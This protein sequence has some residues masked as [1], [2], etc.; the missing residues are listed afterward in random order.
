MPSMSLLKEEKAQVA[1]EYLLA[2]AFGIVLT[3]S[4]A[5]ILETLRQMALQAQADLLT[6]RANVLEN[7]LQ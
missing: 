6:E 2:S 1:F 3:I 7:I 4:A 5:L